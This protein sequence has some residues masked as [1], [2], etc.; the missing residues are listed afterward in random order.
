MTKLL[1]RGAEGMDRRGFS[2][3]EI[4]AMQE[5][6]I[7]DP[8]EKFEVFDGEIVPMNAQNMPHM[9]WKSQIARWLYA[10]LPKTL[11]VVQEGTL[12]LRE[13]PALVFEPDFMIYTPQKGAKRITPALTLL[14]IEVSDT[15]R[16]RDLDIK[17]PRYGAFGVPELW[18]ID[19]QAEEVIV[20]R[21]PQ[22]D[23]WGERK[24]QGFKDP[25]TPLFDPS[26]SMVLADIAP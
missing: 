22:A 8:D 16:K 23:G 18:V 12:T 24:F 11:G 3:D 19:L 1:T 26:L 15:S 21:R 9:Q 20:H 2:M 25:L 7:L 17:G 4:F 6:G 13:R 10:H 14:A 5:A